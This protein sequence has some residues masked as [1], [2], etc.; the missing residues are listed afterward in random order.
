MFYAFS[1]TK[2][3]LLCK[4]DIDSY[5]NM[6]KI[7]LIYN[8]AQHYRAEIFQQLDHCFDI[9]FYFGDKYLDVKKMDY[10]LLGG[11][12][13]EVHNGKIGPFLY[14]TKVLC[15]LKRYDVFLM[16]GE[17]HSITTWI[18]MFLSKLFPKKRIYF[19][20]HGW[21]GKETK[22]ESFLKHIL[23]NMPAG[24]FVYGNY[25]K[26]LMIK[27]GFDEKK[28]YVIHNSL[29]YSKQLEIRKQLSLNS[30]YKDYF[31]NDDPVLMFV[32]RL[33][34]VKK[35]D[36]ILQSMDICKKRG[37]NY[38]LILIGGGQELDRLKALAENLDLSNRVW[39]YGPC[40]DETILGNLIYNSDICI[41]PGNIGLTAMHCMVFG[42]PAITHNYFKWQMPEFEAIIE[43]ETGAFFVMDDVQ[44][45]ADCIDS[46]FA[47]KKNKREEVR[48]NCMNE[49]DTQWTPEFQMNVFK[50][51]LK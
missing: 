25:A 49:I 5:R 46:W 40:Y 37:N 41:A 32:G 17:T 8:Y 51:H 6:K 23:D 44:S 28:L 14:Q 20:C 30:L 38:N 42:T 34:P 3:T 36:M 16:I 4:N 43:G 13:E 27:E 22:V 31:E 19:W 21:Y 9:D 15:L 1:N 11:K 10:S 47:A 48:R 39:F 24:L 12:V 45:L 33:D 2:K 50:K 35:L 18:F 29:A 26:R 7:C